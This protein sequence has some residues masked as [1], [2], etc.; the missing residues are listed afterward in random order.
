VIEEQTFGELGAPRRATALNRKG[1]GYGVMERRPRQPIYQS[2]LTR[3]K[4]LR[5]SANTHQ[6][7]A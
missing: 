2:L 3:E 5:V 7:R 6:Q 4:E 1:I